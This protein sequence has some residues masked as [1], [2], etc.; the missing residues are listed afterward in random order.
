MKNNRESKIL[1]F[2]AAA[3]V[4][5]GVA[6]APLAQATVYAAPG[7][8]SGSAGGGGEISV[9]IGDSVIVDSHKIVLKDVSSTTPYGANPSYAATFDVFD[10]SGNKID[11]MTLK[12]PNA[13]SASSGY[14]APTFSVSV[15]EI[16]GDKA[17]IYVTT[18]QSTQANSVVVKATP[19]A[20]GAG[21]VSDANSGCATSFP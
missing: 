19:K 1:V 18:V 14:N 15:K 4:L 5:A 9:S 7:S 21:G 13:G 11:S 10:T 6:F 12:L 17:K 20:R 2:F 16:A 8:G 3:F